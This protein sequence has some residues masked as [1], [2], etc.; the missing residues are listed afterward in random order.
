M[1]ELQCVTS[2]LALFVSLALSLSL[3]L[4]LLSLCLSCWC[5]FK[6]LQR[7]MPLFFS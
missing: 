6:P 7:M 4:C 5:I 3:S 1:S 2:P